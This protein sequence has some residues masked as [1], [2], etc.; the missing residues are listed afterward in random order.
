M[1]RIFRGAFRFVSGA[2][3]TLRGEGMDLEPEDEPA[4]YTA[5]EVSNDFDSV[6]VDQPGWGKEVPDPHRP[7]TP[8]GRMRRDAV[9]PLNRSMQT[10]RWVI[11]PRLG[12]RM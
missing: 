11:T 5:M 10:I 4:R 7:P 9:N 12:P 1:T 3:A 8:L 6:V 2:I